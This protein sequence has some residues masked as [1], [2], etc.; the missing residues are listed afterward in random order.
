[1]RRFLF[2]LLACCVTS[3]HSR[4][5]GLNV[6]GKVLDEK[7][8]PLP[9][10]NIKIE[11]TTIGT[12]A[13]AKGEFS[14]NLPKA[15][16][17]LV[18]SYV[19]YIT[20]EI[21]PSGNKNLV[22]S[23]SPN[24]GNLNEV[25]VVAY[26]TQK[27]ATITG[28]IGTVAAADIRENVNDNTL[29]NITGRTPGVRISQLSSQPGI[30]SGAQSAQST[31]DIRGFAS[32]QSDGV[33]PIQSG[34]PLFVIDGIPTTDASQF[35][36][37]DPN[38]IESFSVLKDGTAAIYGVEAA[39]GVILVTTRKGVAGR[40]KIDYSGNYGIQY[41]TKYPVLSSAAQYAQLYDEL[42]E[43]G[44]LSNNS[45]PSAPTYTAQQIQQYANGTLPSANWSKVL[46]KQ[47]SQQL[48]QHVTISGGS[49]RIQSFTSIGYFQQ[50]GQI[51]SGID[52]D[53]K[54]NLRQNVNA[55]IVKGLTANV[56]LGFNDVNYYAPAAS[57][58]SSLIKAADG[59][60][61]P[62]EP[63]YANGNPNYLQQFP[64]DV[65]QDANIAGL[66]SKD[67][68]GYTNN[69]SR[70]FTGIFSL[71]YQ[72]PGVNGLSAKGQFGYTNNYNEN[73]SFSKAFNEYTYTSGVYQ[74]TQFNG[75][76]NLNESF[77]QN[78]NDNLQLSLNYENHFGKHHVTLLALYEQNYSAGDYISGSGNYLVDLI[79]T[80]NT[81][82]GNTVA[83]GGTNTAQAQDSYVGRLDYDYANKYIFEAAFREEGSS[84]FGPGHQW[85]FFPTVSGAYVISQEQFMKNAKWIDNLKIRASY[86]RQGDDSP[87]QGSVNFPLWQTG[88]VYPAGG[89]V[90]AGGGSNIGTVFGNGGITK[91]ISW[92]SYADPD[93]TWYSSSQTDIGIDASFWNGKLTFTGDVFRR[94]RTG[95]L[96]TS[97]TALPSTF[98]ASVP[99][100]N[101]N[102]DRTQGWEVEFGHTSHIGQVT[103]HVTAN[104]GF[105][106]TELIHWEETSASNPY[107]NYRNKYT[108]RY[109][110]QIWGYVVTGQF[111]NYQQMYTAP[112]QDGAG[113]R[114]LLPGDYEYADLNGDG[115]IDQRDQKVLATGGNRP[116]VYFGSTIHLSWK[117][118][119][120]SFLLQGATDYHISYQDELGRPFYGGANPLEMYNDR[121]H[122]SN[123]FD[124]TGST[125]VPGKY[126]AMGE[127]QNYKDIGFQTIS[128]GAG[129]NVYVIN[130][131][132]YNIYDATYVRLKQLQ[133]SYA[134]PARWYSKAGISKISVVATGYNLFTW[135]KSGLKNFDP[136]YSD[137]NLY[138]YNYPITGNFNLGVHVTF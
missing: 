99:A 110:D 122:L 8:Q 31:I 1:M 120:L 34:G 100:T 52:N 78:I 38:E 129:T 84:L 82:Q 74:P 11:G 132:T 18:V 19:G 20:Q 79:P 14:V 26:G 75:P 135:T 111:Q 35:S 33:T 87:A 68:G 72:I 45:D 13:D 92:Q 130:G 106:R 40:V 51:A 88:Y 115:I 118:F 137:Q 102:S 107:D 91:G 125:W 86:G 109:T 98:G 134:L 3:L 7:N 37:L 12:I 42:Q 81:V 136:E 39:N 2:I 126:P 41:I 4:A 53:K 5:Q 112:I 103:L 32:Y 66:I 36:R 50:G 117:T 24:Q 83:V 89:S 70:N 56:N 90:Y 105:T 64:S 57:L 60:I 58:W 23:L 62:I 49:E 16:S 55:T 9:G 96:A 108:N 6:S 61:P 17:R 128:S 124:P 114:T 97:L 76:S 47:S 138:G 71:N 73:Y 67:L 65:T 127:R 94:N 104:A 123:V 116:L 77:N 43:D 22:I 131:N 113:N 44:L 69:N 10:A 46:F 80:L 119:D 95:L 63:V 85:G 21:D 54:Y 48:D 30:Y 29:N 59:G 25:V 27:K 133:L 15:G 93:L 121:W 101:I 28:A